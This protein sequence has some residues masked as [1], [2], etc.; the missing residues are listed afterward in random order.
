MTETNTIQMTGAL[1]P[2]D[3][4]RAD[5][6]PMA[7]ALDVVRTRSAF[8]VLREAFYGAT[9]FEEFAARTGLSEP[10][11]AARLRELTDEGLLEREPYQEPG[12][13]TR[14]LYRMTEKGADLL[15]ALVALM[16]WGDKWVLPGGAR[17]EI[18]H[19]E[20][21]SAVHAELRCEHGHE[22]GRNE[23]ELARRA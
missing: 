2:R 8:L 3:G 12:Q 23:L 6:C 18:R 11:T 10:V 22:V 20:C 1:E 7:H 13:R 14:R 4:W 17:V 9:R 5:R 15:P 16:Q 19:Q 21:G